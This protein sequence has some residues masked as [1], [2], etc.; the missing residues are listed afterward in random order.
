MDEVVHSSHPTHAQRSVPGSRLPELH[1]IAQGEYAPLVSHTSWTAIL[2]RFVTDPRLSHASR[3]V[4]DAADV[5]SGRNE[6]VRPR[7]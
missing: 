4:R 3:F 1:R 6:T 5:R 2:W 7:P